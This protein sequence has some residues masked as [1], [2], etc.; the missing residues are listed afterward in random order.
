MGYNPWGRKESD[1][2]ERRVCVCVCVCVFAE[3]IREDLVRRMNGVEGPG[4]TQSAQ[5]IGGGT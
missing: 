1:T 2:T 4:M 3:A 5:S